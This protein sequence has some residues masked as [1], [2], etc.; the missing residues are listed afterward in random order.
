MKIRKSFSK[1]L[2]ITKGG[3]LL[4]RKSG[5]SHFLAKK[6]SKL[7]KRK[8]RLKKI[9]KNLIKYLIYNI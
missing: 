8:K 5:I 7:I 1:R 2:K 4:R 9:N 6:S 3:K